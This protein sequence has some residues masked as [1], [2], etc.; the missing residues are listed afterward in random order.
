MNAGCLQEMLPGQWSL[1]S[2]EECCQQ[3]VLAFGECDRGAAWKWSDVADDGPVANCQIGSDPAPPP[4]APR[5][6]PPLAAAAPHGFVRPVR[7]RQTFDQIIIS[8]E[9]QSYHAIDFVA[10]V[11]VV[12]MTG[13]SDRDRI[14]RNRSKPSS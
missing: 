11:T 8:A 10:S 13:T 6:G 3:R 4:V 12:M 1:W 5:R 2:I 7:E 9:F 14:S